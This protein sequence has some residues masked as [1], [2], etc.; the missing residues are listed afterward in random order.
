MCMIQIKINL[1]RSPFKPVLDVCRV[2]CAVFPL[3]GESAN[4]LA[5]VSSLILLVCLPKPLRTPWC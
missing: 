4:Q 1:I 2:H 5:V 3:W